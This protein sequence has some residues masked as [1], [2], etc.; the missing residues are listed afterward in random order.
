MIIKVYDGFSRSITE[1]SYTNLDPWTFVYGFPG[2]LIQVNGDLPIVIEAGTYTND[3][4]FTVEFPCTLQLNFTP[5][6]E[7]FNVYPPFV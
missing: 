7:G 4:W 2:P 5:V 3:L 1:M 6:A